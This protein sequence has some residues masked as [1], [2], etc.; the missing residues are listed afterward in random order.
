MK[1]LT[2]I[3]LIATIAAV[4]LPTGVCHAQDKK[5]TGYVHSYSP[6]E[7]YIVPEDEAVLKK[8]DAWQDLKFGVIFHWGVYS[9]PGVTESWVLCAEEEQWE[10]AERQKRGMSLDQFRKW[11]KTRFF[12]VI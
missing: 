7:G 10:Y 2:R 6:V 9:V 11:L 1:E 12:A 4:I 8:L 3:L 5:L